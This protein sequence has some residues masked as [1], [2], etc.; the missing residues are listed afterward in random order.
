MHYQF[1][2]LVSFS[3]PHDN[4]P[5]N[6]LTSRA[7]NGRCSLLYMLPVVMNKQTNTIINVIIFVRQ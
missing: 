7:W 5:G 3:A 1:P 2:P 6:V 4:L